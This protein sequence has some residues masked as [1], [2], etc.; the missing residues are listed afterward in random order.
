MTSVKNG[1]GWEF[2][3]KAIEF[4]DSQLGM[5]YISVSMPLL[6]KCIREAIVPTRVPA[7]IK[8]TV[9]RIL[10]VPSNHPQLQLFVGWLQS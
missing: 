8:F 1:G 3:V 2:I 4:L 5:E 9:T 7:S 10:K 6:W